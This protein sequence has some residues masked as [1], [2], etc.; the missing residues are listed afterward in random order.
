MQHLTYKEMIKKGISNQF[1]PIFI[2]DKFLSIRDIAGDLVHFL[3][4]SALGKTVLR[5]H[6]YHHETSHFTLKRFSKL[7]NCEI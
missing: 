5:Q 4:A 2:S 7:L 6:L 3:P 1:F